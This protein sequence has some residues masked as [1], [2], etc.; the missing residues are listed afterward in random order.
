MKERV[1][2][3]LCWVDV[4]SGDKSWELLVY[5]EYHDLDEQ[6]PLICL[7]LC[8][9]TLED[10]Q[11]T[12]DYLQWA[13]ENMIKA[14]DFIHYY[15]T[16]DAVYRDWKNMLGEVKSYISPIANN[17]LYPDNLRVYKDRGI[18]KSRDSVRRDPG[19]HRKPAIPSFYPSISHP[20]NR[21]SQRLFPSF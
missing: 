15:K 18:D 12:D 19:I 8:L 6:N 5:D 14:P 4:K 21:A 9:Y 11:D 13:K 1:F 2:D 16:L 3:W 17:H 20:P 7:Y 10:Y